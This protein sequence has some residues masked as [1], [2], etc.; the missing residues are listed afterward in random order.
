MSTPRFLIT[1]VLKPVDDVRL[2]HKLAKS[3]HRHFPDAPID[4][5]A[6]R[7]S[8]PPDALPAKI[9]QIPLFDFPRLSP[10]RLLANGRLFFQLQRFKPQYLIVATFELLPAALIYKWIWGTKLIYDVQENY[11]A[12]ILYTRVFP[13][14]LRI[15]LA[16]MVRIIEQSAHPW[17]DLYLLAEQCYQEELAFTKKK[18]IRLQNKVK[19]SSLPPRSHLESSSPLSLL[20]TGTISEEYG[21]FR[22]IEWARRLHQIQIVALKILGFAPRESDRKRLKTLLRKHAFIQLE[23]LDHWL[24]HAQIMEALAQTDFLLLPYLPNRSVAHRIPTKLFEAL[25]LRKKMLI[26][27]NPFWE[28]YLTRYPFQAALFI[29]FNKSPSDLRLEEMDKNNFYQID[30]LPANIYWEEEVQA[31]LTWLRKVE[32][33]K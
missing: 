23:G 22:A 30:H 24:P 28:E 15:P 8:V 21:V 5:L 16:L 12:N 31:F 17:V 29:D 25:A 32:A 4:I 18:S 1:S 11:A 2:Y 27:E 14:F 13:A 20:Y 33:K 3:I 9:K 10:R 26:Q 6:F 7:G 19:K